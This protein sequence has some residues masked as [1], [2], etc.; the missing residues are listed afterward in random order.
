[1]LMTETNKEEILDI[2]YMHYLVQVKKDK[3]ITLINF[4]N[5]FNVQACN[6]NIKVQNIDGF[7][8]KIFEIVLVNF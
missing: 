6:T 4:G 1:M 7:N 8:F 3:I 5:K 2:P